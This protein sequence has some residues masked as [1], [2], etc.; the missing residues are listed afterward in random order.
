MRRGGH[1]FEG[2]RPTAN[3]RINLTLAKKE[4]TITRFLVDREEWLSN[5]QTRVSL[6]DNLGCSATTRDSNAYRPLVT[7]NSTRASNKY[8]LA[9]NYQSKSLRS[10]SERHFIFPI[11]EYKDDFLSRINKNLSRCISSPEKMVTKDTD[12]APTLNKYCSVTSPKNALDFRIAS[13]TTGLSC[14]ISKPREGPKS[15]FISKP[16]EGAKSCFMSKL[17]EGLKIVDSKP[18]DNSAHPQ[19]YESIQ[20]IKR[21]SLRDYSG[22]LSQSRFISQP[23]PGSSNQYPVLNLNNFQA[24]NDKQPTNPINHQIESLKATQKYLPQSSTN[25]RTLASNTMSI[26]NEKVDLMTSTLPQNIREST[27]TAHKTR[28]PP[29]YSLPIRYRVMGT[30]GGKIASRNS[31]ALEDIGEPDLT[32]LLSPK[33]NSHF[34][35][36]H[37]EPTKSIMIADTSKH[38]PISNANCRHVLA[39]STLEEA[40]VIAL[41]MGRAI[42]MTQSLMHSE[43]TVLESKRKN[44]I[45]TL[46]GD[47]RKASPASKMNIT[48]QSMHQSITSF[49]SQMKKSILKKRGIFNEAKKKRV[50]INEQENKNHEI[51]KYSH[52]ASH[53]MENVQCNSHAPNMP[54]PIRRVRRIELSSPERSQTIRT[55]DGMSGQIFPFLPTSAYSSNRQLMF[56]L[57]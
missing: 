26:G 54:T 32:Q 28:S 29:N 53:Y 10:N 19:V 18:K 46:A 44:L 45:A 50:L 17:R 39:A 51:E 9:H 47:M 31:T 2:A 4:P 36:D 11:S 7:P 15:C 38:I 40:D 37:S 22:S 55:S 25:I 5:R 49:E 21:I 14:F 41:Q 13:S 24:T 8:Q 33:A 43:S 48:Q 56:H 42:E 52:S 1:S 6:A 57:K 27:P 16:R 35:V 20:K 12:F 3:L 30:H 34:L 23:L